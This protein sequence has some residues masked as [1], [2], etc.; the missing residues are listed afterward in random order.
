MSHL[1]I[2]PKTF[3]IMCMFSFV[4]CRL[5]ITDSVH[6]EAIWRQILKIRLKTDIIEIRDLQFRT[7]CLDLSRT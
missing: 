3:S 5:G 1:I 7:N 4:L 6:R 2:L